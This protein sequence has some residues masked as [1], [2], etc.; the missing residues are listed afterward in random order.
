RSKAQ[1]L[2]EPVD[3]RS[4]AGWRAA[5]TIEGLFVASSPSNGRKRIVV[6]I[7]RRT[8]WKSAKL[9]P[10]RLHSTQGGAP[11]RAMPRAWRL[12]GKFLHQ[13]VE[14]HAMRWAR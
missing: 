14:F 12:P 13:A 3:W 8:R 1:G 6:R 2:V 4:A 9:K 5:K 10:V 7:S 11:A